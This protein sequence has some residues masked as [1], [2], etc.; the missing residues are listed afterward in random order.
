[1]AFLGEQLLGTVG[2]VGTMLSDEI[3]IASTIN[4]PVFVGRLS[5][6][7]SVELRTTALLN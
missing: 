4:G 1:M 5:V 3:T 7:V 6:H 2:I